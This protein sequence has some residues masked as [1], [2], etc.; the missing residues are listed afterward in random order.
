MRKISFLFVCLLGISFL[1]SSSLSAQIRRAQAIQR[2]S[3]AQQG[4][5]ED[6]SDAVF[7]R[8]L[9]P[10]RMD[11]PQGEDGH[12]HSEE[13]RLNIRLSK[14]RPAQRMPQRSTLWNS[15]AFQT[16]NAQVVSEANLRTTYRT[17]SGNNYCA[18]PI[19][20]P[21]LE[22]VYAS[23]KAHMP[24]YVPYRHSKV[25]VWQGFYYN[26]DKKHGAIDY[27][28]SS[29]AN[30]ED[31]TFGVYSIADGKVIDVKWSNGGG[32]VVTIEHTAPNGFKYRS[33]YLHLRNGFT[34]DI[35]KAKQS[36]SSKYKKFAYKPNPS[37][38]CWGKESQK[39]K[40]SVGQTVKAGQMIAWTGNTGS[41]GIG[42]ILDDNGN[43]KNPTTSFNVHIHFELRIKDNNGNWVK[44]DPYGVYNKK[45]GIDCYDLDSETPYARLFAPFYPSFHN[46]P[47]QYVNQYWGYYTGM[48]MALQ[49]ISIDRN[50]GG[51][52]MAS[53]SFQWGLPN[54]WYA[55]FYMSATSYQ[56]YFNQYNSQGFHPR[57]IQVS[58]DSQ[59][60][61][62]FSVI[63][64]KNKAGEAYASFH[65][66]DDNN[67]G[68]LWNN[69][70][71]TKKWKLGEHVTYTMGGKRYHAG[72]FTNKNNGFYAYYGMSSGAFNDK[73]KELYSKWQ[74]ISMHVNGSTVGGLWMPKSDNY[75]AYYGLT[76]S[77][78][79]S[80]FNQFSAQGMRLY[81]LQSYNN[82][83]R[84]AAI[85]VK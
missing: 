79:Q 1:S 29:V 25:T 3:P 67:F 33:T 4:D 72:V 7:Y 13:P 78:Y 47:L 56:N 11:I 49:T 20:E 52:L 26:W 84:F 43:F 42:I 80:K 71:K 32:N 73:F 9:P 30:G 64:A 70:V 17:Y 81:K 66:R 60:N 36:P 12:D 45:S 19:V 65:N 82:S 39:I 85:W 44:V 14:A 21:E 18:V 24:L 40:V 22:A 62:R 31:P 35:N 2:V 77:A 5:P 15:N 53:G 6:D 58:K 63:W 57:Q 27:G 54:S 83:T 50:S 55:R 46:V 68:S 48:G 61:P 51:K 37:T 69:Y 38:L 23:A 8:S 10:M 76:P 74:L 41:G 75:A 34:H 59:G 28:K 16:G